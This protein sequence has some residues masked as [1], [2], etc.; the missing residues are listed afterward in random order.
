MSIANC[1][2]TIVRIKPDGTMKLDSFS[3][4]GHISN[5]MQTYTGGNNDIKELKIKSLK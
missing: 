3:D 2:L 4:S 5:N 1:S